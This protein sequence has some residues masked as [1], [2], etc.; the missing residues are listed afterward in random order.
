LSHVAQEPTP[1]RDTVRT[2]GGDGWKKGRLNAT[3]EKAEENI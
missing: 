1:P 2:A 3:T